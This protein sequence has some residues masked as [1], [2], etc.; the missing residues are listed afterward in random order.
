MKKTFYILLSLSVSVIIGNYVVQNYYKWQQRMQPIEVHG[1]VIKK[2]QNLTN[3][4]LTS[5]NGE[6]FDDSKLIGSWSIMFFGYTRCPDICPMTLSTLSSMYKLLD[7]SDRNLSK[8]PKMIFISID[9][10]HD[11]SQQVTNYSKYFNNNFIGLTG[12]QKQVNEITKNLGVVVQKVKLGEN[13]KY[14]AVDQQNQMNTINEKNNNIET[15][16]IFDHSSTLFV[17]NPK[18]QLQAILTAPHKAENLAKDVTAII[19]KYS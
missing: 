10:E 2:P 4:N 18:G 12:S 13:G 19:N 5:K 11:N 16:Y 1:T 6:L 15:S 14:S 9:P 17:I 3:F 8:L 7:H